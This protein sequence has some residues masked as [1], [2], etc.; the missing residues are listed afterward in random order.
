MKRIFS[1]PLF[2]LM[3]F[4][5]LK[6]SGQTDSS[7][8]NYIQR[9]E[10]KKLPYGFEGNEIYEKEAFFLGRDLRKFLKL[11]EQFGKPE[12]LKDRF[13]VESRVDISKGYYSLV[14]GFYTSNK[15][16]ERHLVNYSLNWKVEGSQRISSYGDETNYESFSIDQDM[17]TVVLRRGTSRHYTR[18]L[19]NSKGGIIPFLYPSV[20]TLIRDGHMLE[21]RVVKALNGLIYRDALGQKLGKLKLGESV[22]IESYSRDSIFIEVD[23]KTI[24][25]RKAK[26][27]LDMEAF[28]KHSVLSEINYSAGY[29]AEYFLFENW[30]DDSEFGEEYYEIY[31]EQRGKLDY[32]EYD[33]ISTGNRNDDAHINLLELLDIQKVKL[34]DF[35]NQIISRYKLNQNVISQNPKSSF[36]IKF[37]NG[38][39]RVFRDTIY[40][41]SEYS[42]ESNF[43][44]LDFKDI[45]NS[46]LIFNAFFEGSW[47]FLLDLKNGDTLC[48]FDGYPCVSPHKKWIISL[49]TPF[50]Y[51][52]ETGGLQ[53]VYVGEKEYTNLVWIN[54]LKWSLPQVIEVYWLSDEEFI[55]KVKEPQDPFGENQKELI[56]YLKFKILL[57]A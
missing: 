48:Y 46:V 22:H 36:E 27:V 9:L 6:V 37:A 29:V 44:K 47:F 23:G 26:I 18:Y 10:I 54:F 11:E 14:I 35:E 39:K 52:W 20:G 12:L 16:I 41:D 1:L 15:K 8:S 25:S 19:F 42:P 45:P 55:L 17:L 3:I 21:V 30:F 53:L 33:N 57:K 51:E 34:K 31:P 13:W 32:Y 43:E 56:F 50:D 7:I 40:E 4:L 49:Q 38:E 2:I 28:S 24:K 5:S